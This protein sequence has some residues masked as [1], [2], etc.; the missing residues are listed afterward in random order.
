MIWVIFGVCII[1]L[2]IGFACYGDIMNG[3]LG[4]TLIGIGGFFVAITLV[5][6]VILTVRVSFS[7]TIDDKIAMYEE[8]NAKIESQIEAAVAKY[9]EYESETFAVTS[10]ESEITLVSLYPEL[11]SDTLI[12]SQIDIYTKNNK[13]IVELKEKK[14][15]SGVTRWW[16]YFG[17]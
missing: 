9:M 2:A 7:K 14:I 13:K 1:L 15:D 5:V 11:K 17:K 4:E 3:E 8:E 16:L 12:A 10:S 6:A